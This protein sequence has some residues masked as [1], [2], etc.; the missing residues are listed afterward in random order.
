[1]E[2]IGKLDKLK[3][4]GLDQVFLRE[5]WLSRLEFSVEKSV[6]IFHEVR[7][8]SYS[9]APIFMENIGRFGKLKLIGLDQVFLK[10]IITLSSPKPYLIIFKGEYVFC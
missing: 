5:T 1:M 8:N 7:R 2:N 3:L 10:P 4:I 9:I 6:A